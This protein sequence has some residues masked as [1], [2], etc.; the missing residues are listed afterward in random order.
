MSST[1]IPRLSLAGQVPNVP[2]VRK[3]GRK[4]EWC[5]AVIPS[6]HPKDGIIATFRSFDTPTLS[7]LPGQSDDTP[8]QDGYCI[9]R[10]GTVRMWRKYECSSLNCQKF[11]LKKRSLRCL[12]LLDLIEL[13]DLLKHVAILSHWPKQ[14]DLAAT[15]FFLNFP[16]PRHI[17]TDVHCQH[18]RESQ[19]LDLA[20]VTPPCYEKKKQF[21]VEC[22]TSVRR[23]N[24]PQ[25]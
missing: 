2:T 7:R 5:G 24:F 18:Y 15:R 21:L 22:G 1:C 8:V 20:D 4:F 10:T 14:S 13:F 16:P 11:Q 25:Q 9:F 6:F 3:M 19:A 23:V 12:T 17:H